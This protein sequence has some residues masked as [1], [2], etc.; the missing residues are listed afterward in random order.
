MN[1]LGMSESVS[2]DQQQPVEPGRVGDLE[3]GQDLDFQRRS[4]RVQRGAWLAMLLIVIAALL[5]LFG[6]EGVLNQAVLGDSGDALRVEYHQFDRVLDQTHL[7]L[8]VS[9]AGRLWIANSYLEHLLIE[10]IV[11]EPVQM[12]AGDERTTLVFELAEAEPFGAVVIYYKPQRVGL[13]SGQIGVDGGVTYA[14][15]QFIYP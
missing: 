14:F 5:G 15:Q 2:M 3:I 11:P 1:M 4:W 7:R 13:V 10:A 12:I 8:E 6:G 9:G